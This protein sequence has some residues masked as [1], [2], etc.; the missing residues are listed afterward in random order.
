MLSYKTHADAKSLYNTP[1]T[2]AIYIASLC[3][4]WIQSHG[5]L[6]G[7]G[8]HNRGKADR[9][10]AALDA[11]DLYEPTAERAS[12]SQMNVTF[13]LTRPDLEKSFL[14]GAESRGLVG[15]K[16]HRSVGGMRASLYNAM[17]L[18]GVESLVGYLHEFAKTA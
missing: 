8:E 14:A 2:W 7:M 12:R 15:L 17:P 16:G 18:A 10:Y 4:R 3:A 1:P 5:G 11:H 9:L 6:T 13:R